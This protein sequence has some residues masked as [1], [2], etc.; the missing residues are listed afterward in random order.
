MNVQELS[1]NE[2]LLAM[3]R[4]SPKIKRTSIVC[5]RLLNELLQSNIFFKSE[6]MQKTGSF[7]IR[8][9]F[10]TIL[11]L[12]ENNKL[13][14]KIVAYSSGNHGQAVA[15]VCH[16]LGLEAILCLPEFISEIKRQAIQRYGAKILITKTRAEAEELTKKIAQDEGAFLIN[17]SDNDTVITGAGTTCLEGLEDIQKNYNKK[18]DR[19]FV[20]CGGG[21]LLSGSYLAKELISPKSKIYGVEPLNANDASISYKTGNIFRFSDSPKTIADGVRTL[22][23]SP[24]TFQYI[25]KIDDFV[26][27]EEEQIVYWTQWLFHLLK[28][29]IEPTSALTMAGCFQFLKRNKIKN[30]NILVILSGGNISQ[31]SYKTIWQDNHLMDLPTL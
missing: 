5:S 15:Y 13:P 29:V 11:S 28:M 7:K 9:V 30:E 10:N 21:G 27:V 3:Q 19:I 31:E 6:A 12:Q 2:L 26:E 17:P 4:I 23:I 8:G 20:N 14:K 24:R 16:Q 22:S 18:I 25:K 1:P